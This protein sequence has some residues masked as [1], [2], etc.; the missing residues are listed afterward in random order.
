M[1]KSDL[2]SVQSSKVICVFTVWA[3]E[4]AASSKECEENGGFTST[5]NLEHRGRSPTSETSI[6]SSHSLS[7]FRMKNSS[8]AILNFFCN[9]FC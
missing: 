2:E 6:Q 9:N 8:G 4:F 5:F 3:L 1:S 7:H